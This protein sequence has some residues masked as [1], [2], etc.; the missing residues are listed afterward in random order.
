M[1]SRSQQSSRRAAMVRQATTGET[2]ARRANTSGFVVRMGR[3]GRSAVL[4]ELVAGEA[5]APEVFLAGWLVMW[6]I[7][8]ASTASVCYGC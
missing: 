6:T 2:K 3:S 1:A 4:R 8:G 5:D 7:G